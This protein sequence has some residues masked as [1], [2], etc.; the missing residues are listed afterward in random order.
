MW[1][2]NGAIADL[3]VVWAMTDEGIRGFL[4]DKGTPGFDA[5]VIE[6]KF[7]LRA[8]VTSA[9]F[10]DNVVVPE[11]NVL[12]GA[13]GLKGPLA[14]LTQARYGISWGV[15]GAAQS[16]LAQLLERSEEHTS[17]L[18]SQ[19]NLVCR[20]LLE[21]KKTT[22]VAAIDLPRCIA[23]NS[24]TP[25]CLYAALYI[26]PT[27]YTAATAHHSAQPLSGEPETSH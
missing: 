8:S 4:V 20:L 21:K 24:C 1:I 27:T 18:Q 23:C 12:P 15:I 25:G 9:L 13:V 22:D 3:A 6:H 5:T 17:E 16:C 14:C 7:S 26:A 11:Q 19:S 10:F 2:T